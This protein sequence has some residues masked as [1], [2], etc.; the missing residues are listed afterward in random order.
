ME[1]K[2]PKDVTGIICS[3]CFQIILASTKEQITRAYQKTLHA[4]LLDKAKAL[5]ILLVKEIIDNGET[6]KL[7]RDMDRVRALRK[8]R[9][10]D[11]K[12]RKEHTVRQLDKRR[13]AVC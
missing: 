12:V 8:I 10:A 2:H 13:V 4:G 3:S 6:K 5:E 9:P 1:A 11:H 7:S